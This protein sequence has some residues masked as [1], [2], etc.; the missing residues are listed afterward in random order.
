MRMGPNL[1]AKNH[2]DKGQKSL[3]YG[4]Q[5]SPFNRTKKVTFNRAIKRYSIKRHFWRPYLS[6]SGKNSYIG[7]RPQNRLTSARSQN[8]GKNKKRTDSTP[9][10]LFPNYNTGDRFEKSDKQ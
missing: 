7:F 6:D 10:P 1:G 4:I 2:V 3:K 5:N 8:L 9:I